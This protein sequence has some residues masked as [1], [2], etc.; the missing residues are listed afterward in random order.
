[1]K[2]ET[3]MSCL[4]HLMHTVPNAL[5]LVH[6]GG[7]YHREKSEL[8]NGPISM[9]GISVMNEQKMSDQQCLTVQGLNVL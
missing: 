6:D 2:I 1:M 9:I 4:K 7:P 5:L 8:I 3:L